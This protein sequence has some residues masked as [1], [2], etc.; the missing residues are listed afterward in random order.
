MPPHT[1]RIPGPPVPLRRIVLG[2]GWQE[3]ATAMAIATELARS[4]Q[5]QLLGLFVEDIELLHFA[6]LP[7]ARELCLSSAASR[8]F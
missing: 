3:S 7:F 1:D 2:L 8:I 5:L 4:L 6:A